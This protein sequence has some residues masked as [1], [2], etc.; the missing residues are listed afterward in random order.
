M[1]P[2]PGG[3]GARTLQDTLRLGTA[4]ILRGWALQGYS[5]VGHCKDTSWLD[6]W[7]SVTARI[8]CAWALQGNSAVRHCQDTWWLDTWWLG[9]ARILCGWAL[10]EYVAIEYW[11][12][13]PGGGRGQHRL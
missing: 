8:L 7:W 6:T 11:S 12:L 2:I 4:R 13:A 5:A 10:Q 9:T 1:L 3:L